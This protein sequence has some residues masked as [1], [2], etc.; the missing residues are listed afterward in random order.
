MLFNLVELSDLFVD[1]CV[2]NQAGQ[3]LFMSCYGRDTALQQLLAA[4]QLKANAGGLDHFRLEDS[5]SNLETVFVGDPGR[6]EKFNG[7]LPR[8]NLFGNLVH[9]WIYDPAVIR[10]D[11]A[12]RSSWVIEPRPW[13]EMSREEMRA[14]VWETYRV[15]SPVPLLDHWCDTLLK[16]TADHYV[17]LMHQTAYKPVGRCWAFRVHL[18]DSFLERVSMLVKSGELTL[19]PT[20]KSEQR[21]LLAA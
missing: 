10:P 11:F 8:E 12:N 6:L 2:R 18:D 9:T 13:S 15:L 4:F 20:E 21:Q 1:A 14:K 7:R 16:A 5:M 3:L 17:T 19:E